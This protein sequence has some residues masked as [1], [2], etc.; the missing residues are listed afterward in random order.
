M[1]PLITWMAIVGYA[2]LALGLPL[3]LSGSNV[4]ADPVAS[5]RVAA[6]DRSVPFPCMDKP[7]GCAS[8]EQC[9]RECCC[10]TP[11]ERLAWARRNGLGVDMLVALESRTVPGHASKK[12]GSCERE[13]GSCCS[14]QALPDE[15]AE[16]CCKDGA[17][18]ALTARADDA[19]DAADEP[20]PRGGTRPGRQVTLRGMLACQGAVGSWISVGASLP[21]PRIELFVL[22]LSRER[23]IV[24]DVAARSP[25]PDPVAPPPWAA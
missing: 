24:S 11:A 19:S 15:P 2:L 7:C 16:S 3:P 5:R 14:A 10:T 4:A 6:K 12:T 20:V 13:R 17:G 25:Q 9:F 8:A 22:F 18:P 23:L 1:R 21:P